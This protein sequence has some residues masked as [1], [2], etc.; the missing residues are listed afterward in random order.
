MQDAG[1]VIRFYLAGTALAFV[2]LPV[3]FLFFKKLN[4]HLFLYSRILGLLLV[5][6]SVGFL[7]AAGILGFSFRGILAAMLLTGAAGMALCLAYKIKWS[8]FQAWFQKHWKTFLFD[9][10]VFIL[11]TLLFVFVISYQPKIF[12]TEKNMDFAFLNSLMRGEEIPPVDPWFAGG[13]INYYYGGYMAMA[14]MGRLSGLAPAYTYNLALAF[15]FGWGFALSWAIGAEL[16]RGRFRGLAAPILLVFM[17][18]LDGFLQLFQ[19][20]WPFRINYWQSSRVILDGPNNGETINEFPFFSFYHADLHPHV[21][22]IVFVLLFMAMLLEVFL[23]FRL[24]DLK[25]HP[26]KWAGRLV[27]LSIALGSLGFVNGFDLITFGCL[28]AGVLSLCSI[29]SVL[30]RKKPVPAFSMGA[31]AGGF[32]TGVMGLVAYLS[33]SFFYLDFVAPRADEKPVQLADFHSSFGQFMTVFHLQLYL[34][35]LYVLIRFFRWKTDIGRLTALC[36]SALL[37][38]LGFLAFGLW[39]HLVIAVLVVLIP[40]AVHAVMR[41]FH[42][43]GEQFAALSIGLALAVLLGCEFFFFKDNYG[44]QRMNTLFKFHYQA[45]ILLALAAPAVLYV[46]QKAPTIPVTGKKLLRAGFGLLLA[47]NLVYPIGILWNRL[48]IKKPGVALEYRYPPTLDGMRYL[49]REHPPEYAAIQWLN[50]NVEGQPVIL[51][52]PASRAY[53]YEARVST[54]TG[55]PTVIGWLN[56]ESIWRKQWVKKDEK[57]RQELEKAGKPIDGWG[58]VG[59]RRDNV[60]RIY[61]SAAMES[62]IPLLKR[63]NVQYIYVGE[64]EKQ[65]YPVESLQ[66]FEGS[67]ERVYSRQGVSIYE[68]PDRMVQ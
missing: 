47:F 6:F 66:K 20:G 54:N 19:V 28:L 38:M 16:G 23:R 31:I 8:D 62:I 21:V 27:L 7:S 44:I 63:Y 13:T 18:N 35:A 67:L 32:I 1:A 33:F 52:Y 60:E 40:L 48:P 65:K 29:R 10:V 34:V 39:G 49:E 36:L 43:P 14:L 46:L 37:L 50:E 41:T 25:E 55:L 64:L 45:W 58:L 4:S 2:S 3:A 24:P 26:V 61:R 51:E 5:N 17:G 68:V 42:R 12:G 15:L 53:S 22:G 30:P 9:E 57:H 56:H 11:A 59:L